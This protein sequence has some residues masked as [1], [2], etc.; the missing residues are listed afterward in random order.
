M[1]AEYEEPSGPDRLTIGPI[2]E[3]TLAVAIVEAT[4]ELKGADPTELEPLS[5]RIDPESIDRLVRST[6]AGDGASPFRLSFRYAGYDVTVR[7]PATVEIRDADGAT[8]GDG[9]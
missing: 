1:T 2:R 8:P 7:N 5:D 4:A 9:A 6:G 3:R